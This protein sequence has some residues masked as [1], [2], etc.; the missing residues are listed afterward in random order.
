MKSKQKNITI[1][2]YTTTSLT[3]V[4]NTVDSYRNTEMDISILLQKLSQLEV[5][6]RKIN[7]NNELLILASISFNK[8]SNLWELIFYKSRSIN[9]PFIIDSSGNSRKIVL[10]N[11]EMIS[12]AICMLYD[13]NTKILAMQRNVYAVGTKGIETFLSSFS[14]LP[15]SLTCITSITENKRKLLTNLKIKKFKLV[16]KNVKNKKNVTKTP[17]TQ[18]NKNTTICKVIDSALA[19]NSST[20]NIEFSMGNS[21]EILHLEDSDFEVFQKLIDNNNVRSLELG[22]VSNQNDNMQITDFIDSRITDNIILSFN[23]GETIDLSIL[24]VKMTEKMKNNIYIN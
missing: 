24:L 19:V 7:Y 13:P 22:C 21:S 11:G 5:S 2:Y 4:E 18:Y 1:E 3:K 17:I 20:I 16:V 23:K 6:K 14:K 12:E 10:K 8:N 15:I 9:V